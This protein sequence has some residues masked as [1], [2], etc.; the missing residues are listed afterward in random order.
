MRLLLADISRLQ[1]VVDI[2]IQSGASSI[3]RRTFSLHDENAARA[4]ALSQAAVQARSGAEALA[5]SLKMQL[6]RLL[7]VEEGQ[8]VVVSTP[9]EVS[10]EKLQS[11]S[12]AP[13]TPGTVD[14]HADVDLTYEIVPSPAR[15]V[16]AR[17]R[18]VPLRRQDTA[19]HLPPACHRP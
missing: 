15:A 5:A 7:R 8:P 14:V 3:N 10:F 17:L 11:A 12:L 4:H 6:Q 16:S 19:D 9:R 18:R 13:I 1:T 2:A